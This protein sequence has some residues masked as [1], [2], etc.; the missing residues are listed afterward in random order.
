MRRNN[1]KQKLE[2]VKS[3]CRTFLAD[4]DYFNL[5]FKIQNIPAKWN[6]PSR[7]YLDQPK[8]YYNKDKAKIIHY[9]GPYKPWRYDCANFKYYREY[10]RLLNNR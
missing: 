2:A 1:Y 7:N 6:T 10:Q 3:N 9:T 4:Q 5:A 8:E